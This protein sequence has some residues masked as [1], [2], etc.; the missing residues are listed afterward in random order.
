MNMQGNSFRV[1]HAM[2]EHIQYSNILEVTQVE[3][4]ANLGIAQTQVARAIKELVREKAIR[5]ISTTGRCNT[6]EL[7]PELGYRGDRFLGMIKALK[8][9]QA[10]HEEYDNDKNKD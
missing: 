2:I 6:Y 1:L 4:A 10:E 9:K 8:Y 5:L 7:N 3:I